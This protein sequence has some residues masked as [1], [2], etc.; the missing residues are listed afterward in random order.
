MQIMKYMRDRIGVVLVTSFTGPHERQQLLLANMGK[1]RF[2]EL[3]M[4]KVAIALATALFMSFIPS[5]AVAQTKA[6]HALSPVAPVPVVDELADARN[7][8]DTFLK[9]IMIADLPEGQDMLRDIQWITGEADVGFY[10]RPT[11]TAD[12]TIFEKLFDT[13]IPG[14]QGYKRLLEM[15]AVSEARTPLLVR[16]LMI[17][18]KDRRT[19]KWKVLFTGTGDRIAIDKMVT[20]SSK[21]IPGSSEQSSYGY[22]GFWLLMAGQ[23]TEAK[24]AF[25]NSLS[26]KTTYTGLFDGKP[27]EDD[28]QTIH[29]RLLESRS[30]LSVID[31]ITGQNADVINHP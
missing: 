27:K 22:Y 30:L 4:G 9:G 10:E 23:I 18:Y 12:T 24:Q 13:D 26:A 19:K 16:Y 14:V 8:T 17:A 28:I 7:A 2:K 3:T 29:G 1:G 25:T 5:L 21:G 20:W 15:T 31:N 11:F 6:R